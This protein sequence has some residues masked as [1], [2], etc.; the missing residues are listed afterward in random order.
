MD[1]N[2]VRISAKD[3]GWWLMMNGE[4]LMVVNMNKNGDYIMVINSYSDSYTYSH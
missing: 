4:L 2:Q 1:K 3:D